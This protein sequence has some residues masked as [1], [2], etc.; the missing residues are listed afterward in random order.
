MSR[1]GGSSRSAQPHR[2]GRGKVPVLPAG[3]VEPGP[4]GKNL[5]MS[6]NPQVPGEIPHP[7][8]G[9]NPIEA[10]IKAGRN[11]LTR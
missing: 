4:G 9:G 1:K 2:A 5:G 8:G 7:V 3:T 11:K 10:F 6:F